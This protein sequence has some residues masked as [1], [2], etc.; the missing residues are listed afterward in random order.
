MSFILLTYFLGVW[1]LVQGKTDSFLRLADW[2]EM[3]SHQGWRKAF[4][5]PVLT[6]LGVEIGRKTKMFSFV[7][8]RSC[9]LTKASRSVTAGFDSIRDLFSFSRVILDHHKGKAAKI[10]RHLVKNTIKL[11]KLPI[12]GVIYVKVAKMLLHRVM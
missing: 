6:L 4:S 7:R 11:V 3:W 1:N 8:V 2:R 9:V 10:H 5:T 12:L